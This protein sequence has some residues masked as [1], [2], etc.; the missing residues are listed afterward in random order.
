MIE[1]EYVYVNIRELKRGLELGCGYGDFMLRLLKM[2]FDVYG[3]DICSYCVKY[4]NNLFR[5][6]GFSE[7]CHVMDAESL[8]FHDDS[9]DFIYVIISLHEMDVKRV[10]RENFRVLKEKGRFIDIDWAPWADTGA[11]EKYYSIEEVRQAFEY[12]GF[13]T[14]EAFYE[15]DLEY[16]L[17]KK[18]PNI[19]DS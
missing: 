4:A 9:F 7:R 15:G 10:A 19:V 12:V 17:F 14:R 3:V 16:I 2:G 8:S 5:D 1:K 11:F 13:T 6:H 18:N